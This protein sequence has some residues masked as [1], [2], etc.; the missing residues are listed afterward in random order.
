MKMKHYLLNKNF[1]VLASTADY[2]NAVKMADALDG[3]TYIVSALTAAR[4]QNEIKELKAE[5][6]I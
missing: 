4:L 3:D 6:G 2:A 1:E 5:A